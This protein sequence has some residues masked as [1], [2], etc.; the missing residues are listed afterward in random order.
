MLVRLGAGVFLVAFGLAGAGSFVLMVL[1]LEAGGA[2][3]NS[4]GSTGCDVG[5]EF[6]RSS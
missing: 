5:I 2:S 1:V 4:A 6:D 3:V